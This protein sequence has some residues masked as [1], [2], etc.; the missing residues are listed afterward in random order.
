M[1]T[2]WTKEEL[3]RLTLS[4]EEKRL[5]TQ[6]T[7]ASGVILAL[8]AFVLIFLLC[9][10]L[11]SD[12]LSL[13]VEFTWL[14]Y[15]ADRCFLVEYW[16]LYPIFFLAFFI[17]LMKLYESLVPGYQ[18]M[19]IKL[20][21][22]LNGELVRMPSWYYFFS[23]GFTNFFEELLFRCALIGLLQFMCTLFLDQLSSTIFALVIS[24]LLF[25]LIHSEYRS[26]QAALTTIPMALALGWIYL[27]TG[28]LLVVF[29]T[30]LT[31][32]LAIMYIERFNLYR[33]RNYFHGKIPSTIFI[34]MLNQERASQDDKNFPK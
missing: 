19:I 8:V 31:Y 25:W 7:F 32:N 29:I 1:A 16:Y 9:F 23:M 18:H 30:H 20:R 5:I 34:D 27:H 28:S 14:T 21:Q 24:S 3:K 6:S 26:F 4:R 22:G 11:Y 12:L 13:V 2:G 17:A 33:D 10:F 15:I